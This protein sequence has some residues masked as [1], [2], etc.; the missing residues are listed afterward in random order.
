MLIGLDYKELAT[1]FTCFIEGAP[2]LRE[3]VIREV[4]A[5]TVK[6]PRTENVVAPIGPLDW[7]K[8]NPVM[9]RLCRLAIQHA[10]G[11]PQ[12]KG[13]VG[14]MHIRGCWGMKYERGD[15]AKWHTNF[16]AAWVLTYYAEAPPGCGNLMFDHDTEIVP[17]DGMLC[18]FPAYLPHAVSE[19]RAD[20]RI[21]VGIELVPTDTQ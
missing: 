21:A 1:I 6:Y 16:P 2:G 5:M 7:H 3:D 11:H 18:V 20:R 10:E 9:Q 14:Q 4:L 19:C 12:F 8:T 13:W 15:Y 17:Q